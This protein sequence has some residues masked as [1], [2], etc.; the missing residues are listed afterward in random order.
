VSVF[1]E[2]EDDGIILKAPLVTTSRA[3]EIP[4][5]RHDSKARVW[6]YPLSWSVCVMA[7]G[8]FGDDLEVGPLLIAWAQEERVKRIEPALAAREAKE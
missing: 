2:R 8:V 6:R 4:G 3:R 1:M 7:R 5:A